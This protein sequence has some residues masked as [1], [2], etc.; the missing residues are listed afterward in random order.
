MKPVL[1]TVDHIRQRVPGECVAA[2]AP[3]ILNYMGLLVDYNGLIK[4]LRI[5]TGGTPSFRV[6]DLE[7]LGIT[8]IYK[9]GSFQE[10]REHLLQ[11][12]PCMAFVFTGELPYWDEATSHAVVV[13]GLD[14]DNVYVNDPAF[15]DAPIPVSKGDFDLAWLERDEYY[16]AFLKPD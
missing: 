16:A 7:I 9:Q 12:R 2:C 10:L 8:V 5:T 15:P 13:T 4:L 1:L 14:D 3:M 11:N 6:L